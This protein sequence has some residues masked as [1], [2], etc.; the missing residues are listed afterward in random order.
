V[1]PE[2]D[3]L[4]V[5]AFESASAWED[6]LRENH[7][8]APGVWLKLAK[9]ASGLPSVSGAEAVEV[10]LC[11]G[12][13]D[14]QS[15][16]L[17]ATH[18]LHRHTPRRARS[19]WSKVNREKAE[20]LIEQGRMQLAGLREIER[21]KADGR[22]DAAY[23]PPSRAAVPEDLQRELDARPAAAESFAALNATNRYAILHRLQTAR[24]PETRARRLRKFVEMLERGERLH[25]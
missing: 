25:P 10:S 24:R 8:S 16:S 4:P 15:A 13:I 5:L 12:W 11:Y 18:F 19:V 14:G 21:A 3:G 20:A 1:R 7:G 17:D 6:W 22:W 2:D 23:D 9:K